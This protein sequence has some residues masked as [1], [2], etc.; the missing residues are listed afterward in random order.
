ML[1]PKSASD[2]ILSSANAL[3][4]EVGANLHDAVME[5]IYTDAAQIADRAVVRTDERPRFDLDRAID[6]LVTS[7]WTGFPIMILMLT[8]VFWLTIAG[9]NVPSA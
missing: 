5:A 1:T 3:R 8:V 7:R 4:W 2:D 9:A 6:R